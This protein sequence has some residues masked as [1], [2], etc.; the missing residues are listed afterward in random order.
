MSSNP[1]ENYPINTDYI[2]NTKEKRE[3]KREERNE[4]KKKIFFLIFIIQIIRQ[5]W[6]IGIWGILNTLISQYMKTF[7]QKMLSYGLLTLIALIAIIIHNDL[8]F[9]II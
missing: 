3:E 2:I 4:K 9:E 7:K 5:L 6:W 1:Q 8:N